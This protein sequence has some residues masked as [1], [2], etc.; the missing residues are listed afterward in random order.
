MRAG[1]PPP[2]LPRHTPIKPAVETAVLPQSTVNTPTC[3][4][5]D[6]GKRSTCLYTSRDGGIGFTIQPRKRLGR[7]SA[8]RPRPKQSMTYAQCPARVLCH[9]RT[10]LDGCVHPSQEYE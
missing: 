2:V 6:A 7:C 1:C 3:V 4:T 9:T 8:G 10:G 5:T